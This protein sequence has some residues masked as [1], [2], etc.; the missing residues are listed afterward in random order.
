MSQLIQNA[1]FIPA[2]DLYLVSSHTHDYVVHCFAGVEPP[3]ELGIDGGVSYA[4]RDGDFMRLDGLYEEWCLTTEDPFE[5][6]I[7]DRLLWGTRGKDGMQPLTY[8]PIKELAHRP[9]GL[10]HL[11]AILDNANPG[12]WHR[13]VVEWWMD[14]LTGQPT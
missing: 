12:P 10:N 6:W 8:R 1:V 14:R 3:L 7:T 5:G 4:K 13:Q 2:E 11:Q 9:D